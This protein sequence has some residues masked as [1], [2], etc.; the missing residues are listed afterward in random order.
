MPGRVSLIPLTSAHVGHLRELVEDPD[1]L[2]YTYVP[3]PPPA[4]FPQ[5]WAALTEEGRGGGT[6]D[7]FVAFDGEEFVGF[8]GV[9]RIDADAGEAELGYIVTPAMRGRGYA[10]DLITTATRILLDRG[11]QRVELLIDVTN[12]ASERAAAGAGYVREGVLRNHHF[13]AGRRIDA[14]LWSRIPT[15]P[16]PPNRRSE[17]P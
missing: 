3:D 7:G 12:P 2:R 11:M 13:K 5:V 1:V 6:R 17:A 10:A 4:D 14:A 9:P 15:D 8:V 16:E